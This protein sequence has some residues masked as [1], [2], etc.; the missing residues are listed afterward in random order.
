MEPITTA[1]V[2]AIA[3]GVTAGATGV[4]QQG[5]VDGYEFLKNLI[6]RKFG[7]DSEVVA[8]IEGVEKRP[9]SQSRQTVLQ[10]EIES[11]KVHEDAEVVQAAEQ[12]I[13]QLRESAGGKQL[14][15]STQTAIGSNIAQASGGSQASVNINK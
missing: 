2:A 5:L 7:A 8:A 14:V 10:E 13:A 1:I 11:A 12:L 15:Q 4:G 9:E 3:A 6:S